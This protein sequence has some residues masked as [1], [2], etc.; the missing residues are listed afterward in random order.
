MADGNLGNLIVSV[1]LDAQEMSKGLKKAQSD[2]QEFSGKVNELLGIFGVGLGLAGLAEVT[3]KTLEWGTNLQ[4]VGRQLDITADQVARFQYAAS[5]S[6][7]PIEALQSNFAI[8]TRRMFEAQQGNAAA[9]KVFDDFHISFENADGSLRSFSEILPEI[10]DRISNTSDKSRALAEAQ[11]LLGRSAKETF[12][13]F[14]QGSA[15][16]KQLMDSMPGNSNQINTFARDSEELQKEWEKLVMQMRIMMVEILTPLIPKFEELIKTMQ[17][18][19][20]KKVSADINEQVQF[21]LS[22]AGAITKAY[23]AFINYAK[24]RGE[25]QE[26]ETGQMGL[27]KHIGGFLGAYT[28]GAGLNMGDAWNV[29]GG[30]AFPQPQAPNYAPGTVQAFGKSQIGQDISDL[31]NVDFGGQMGASAGIESFG[32]PG[33]GFAQQP[34]AQGIGGKSFFDEF[35]KD[36][37]EMK[38]KFQSVNKEMADISA[39][40]MEQ[41]STGIGKSF[42]DSIVDGKNFGDAMK[43]MWKDIAKSVIE[44]IVTMITELIL[45]FAW[46]VVTGTEGQ[47]KGVGMIG[48]FFGL[49]SAREG[50]YIPS[51]ANGLV[52]A[53][54]GIV[55]TGNYGEAGIPAIVHPNEIISPVDK[56]FDAV[57]GMGGNTFHV[58]P[59]PG[60]DERALA[61]LVAEEVQ[62][63]QRNP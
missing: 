35:K 4:L 21:W 34:K 52:Y 15:S 26:K 55:S 50:A 31:T 53:A 36:L 46:Q 16:I 3:K 41:I 14:A 22:L 40:T 43:Q 48:N 57:K 45:L 38:A 5:Q 51:A 19:D 8:L 9:I 61:Q 56:F 1:S 29:G 6:N 62:R 23:E 44:Q 27:L 32:Q 18:F 12:G 24:A 20:W 60:M 2:V 42:A 54:S 58:H 7:V 28:S 47:G 11:L 33:G 30:G 39:K 25:K 10:A 63:K 37:D 17:G 49:G 13:F 59:S